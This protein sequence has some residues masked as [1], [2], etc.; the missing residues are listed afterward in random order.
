MDTQTTLST[1]CE[2]FALDN[3]ARR[4]TVRTRAYYEAS[5]RP[6]VIW[7]A[8]QGVELLSSV[9]PTVVRRY[10]VYLQGRTTRAGRPL[11]S[12]YIHNL[13]RALRRLFSYC[14]ADGLLERSPF[15]SVRM[16]RVERKVLRALSPQDVKR[17]LHACKNARDG[18][19]V[20]FLLD[21]GVRAAELC[22]LNVGDLDAS[23]GAVTVA[24]GKGQKGR[25]V[26][27]GAQTRKAVRRYLAS[28][29]NPP[30]REPLF[31]TLRGGRRL[32]VNAIVQLMRRLQ[33]ASGVEHATAHAMRRTFAIT[34]LRNGMNVHTLRL[35]MGHADIDVLRLYLD[36]AEADLATAHADAGPVDHMHE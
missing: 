22:A 36:F 30:A 10:L 31:V 28:R 14:V 25:Y 6:F 17:L 12:T 13:A 34:C 26:Y 2:L 18:A 32:T 8:T 15:Q 23:T 1:A 21:T 24:V 4:L 33:R 27:A 16:P 9:T 35:L 29:N 7:C 19:L 3:E 5:L 11:S 20:R